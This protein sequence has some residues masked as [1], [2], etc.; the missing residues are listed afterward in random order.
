MVLWVSSFFRCRAVAL[1]VSTACATHHLDEPVSTASA[2]RQPIQRYPLDQDEIQL[3][4]LGLSNATEQR[5]LEAYVSVSQA[6]EAHFRF[7]MP[8]NEMTSTADPI[9]N[10]ESNAGSGV[11]TTRGLPVLLSEFLCKSLTTFGLVKIS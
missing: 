2:D 9:V 11:S 8:L 6:R 1:E 5:T 7:R 3:V 10:S 4:Q